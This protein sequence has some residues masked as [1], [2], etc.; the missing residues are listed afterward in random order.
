[1]DTHLN[2]IDLSMQF[3]WVPKK[4]AFIKVDAIQMGI[5]NICFY[6]ENQKN[7]NKKNTNTFVLLGF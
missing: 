2:C 1:M 4:Y 3:K 7:Q 5:H 6:K